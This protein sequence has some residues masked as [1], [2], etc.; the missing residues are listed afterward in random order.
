MNNV[1][2]GQ[3]LTGSPLNSMYFCV[4]YISCCIFALDWAWA[5]GLGT[6]LAVGVEL[7]TLWE[8]AGKRLGR[9]WEGAGVGLENV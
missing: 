2:N 3:Y 5:Q 6:E 7:G 1:R 8:G 4:F 9:D